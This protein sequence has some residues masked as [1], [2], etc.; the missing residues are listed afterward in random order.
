MGKST[1]SSHLLSHCRLPQEQDLDTNMYLSTV[2]VED[3]AEATSSSLLYLTLEAMGQ[4][5]MT[6]GGLTSLLFVCAMFLFV[7]L[8]VCCCAGIKDVNGDH[9]ASHIGKAEG[10]I[11]LIRSTAYYRSRRAVMI[12]M[13]IVMRVSGVLETACLKHLAACDYSVSGCHLGGQENFAL[14]KISSPP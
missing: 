4:C 12:P 7:C 9:A 1:R 14:L 11:T 5:P 10:I 2:E 13:D 6:V 8:F 3:Y